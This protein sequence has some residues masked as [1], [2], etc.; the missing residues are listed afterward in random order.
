MNKELLKVSLCQQA[1]CLPAPP[2]AVPLPRPTAKTLA[3]VAEL[4]KLGYAV[5][6]PLLHALNTLSDD[7]RQTVLDVVN[8][9]M[10]THM[11]WA[12]LV[13][14]WLTPTGEGVWDHFVTLMANV[15]RDKIDVPGTTLPCGHL[16]PNGTFPLERYNGCPFCGTPF[17]LAPGQVHTGQGTK[18][19]VLELWSDKDLQLFY[20]SLLTSPVPLDATQREQLQTLLRWLPLPSP[21]VPISMKETRMLVV[22]AMICRGHDDEAVAFF[23]TPADIMR[24][25]WYAKTNQI[26]LVQPR[27]LLHRMQKNSRRDWCETTEQELK[28]S[29]RL[30]YSRSDCRLAAG[31]LNRLNMP[32]DQQLETMHP[33]RSM[34]VR[35]IRALRL[36]EYARK[37]GYERLRELMDRFYRCDYEV[38]Q[39]RVDDCRLKNDAAKTLRLLSLRPG[40]FARSLFAT[41]LT[42]GRQT[43]IEAFRKVMM[44]VPPRLLLSLDAQAEF[45]FDRDAQRVVHPVNGVLKTIGPH[46]LLAH[47]TDDELTLMRQDVR[48][49]FLDA[50]RRHFAEQ[51]KE[52]HTVFIDGQLYDIPVAVADRS[53]TIQDVS[54]ALQGTRFPVEGEN[55]RLFLQWGQGL[56][57]QHLDMDLSCHILTDTEVAVCSYFNLVTEGARHSGDIQRIPDQVGTAEYIEL[58]IP[59]LEKRGACRVAFTCNAYSDGSLSP[60][61]VVGWMNAEH[62]MKVS[63]ETGVAYDPS[64]VQHMVRIS[65]SNLSKGLIFGVLNVRKREIVWLEMPLDG[66]TVQSISPETVEAFL[67][68]LQAKP[69]IGQMLALRAEAQGLTVVGRADD[70]DEVFTIQWARNTAQVS[71]L[72]FG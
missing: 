70:A 12:S 57:A 32:I 44:K 45:Y 54:A 27:T 28:A 63:N 42:F 49:L 1:L 64:T 5:S 34:W 36:A 71:Q 61:M 14:G 11:N 3:L 22:N 69:T 2:T 23:D 38:W 66:R 68:R 39:G 7:D 16:I 51:A 58:S 52:A 47:Y 50:M 9:V 15:L 26:Q 10:G 8:D 6:E 30:H 56:P 60:N 19:K 62:P 46:P 25:L 4:R 21:D 40:C 35:F 65:A 37:P 59:E 18:L 55:V 48:Q 24:F 43:V 17:H 67:R 31:W 20:H 41:M 72:L 53:S 33:R 13:R 29:L